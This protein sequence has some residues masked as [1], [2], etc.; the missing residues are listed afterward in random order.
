MADFPNADEIVR[1]G[2]LVRSGRSGRRH[3]AGQS[4]HAGRRLWIRTQHRVGRR[5]RENMV[6]PQVSL[7]QMAAMLHPTY[8]IKDRG[9]QRRA[10]DWPNSP[11]L[12]DNTSPAIT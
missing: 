4:A 10:H 11:E 8:K 2:L 7:A 5:T 3:H 12:L 6:W 1:Q 9:R